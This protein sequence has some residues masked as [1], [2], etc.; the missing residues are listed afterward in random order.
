MVE[1]NV[2]YN[3][4]TRRDDVRAVK[5]SSKPHFYNGYVNTFI[6]KVFKGQGCCKFKERRV[7]RLKKLLSFSTKST[8]YCCG[9]ICPLMRIRSLKSTKWG[10]V[11]NP[12]RSPLCWSIAAMVCA[13]LPFPFVPATWIVLNW[14][15]GWLKWASS[16]CV[17]D[18]P[19]L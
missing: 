16:R 10:E 13:Q 3:R 18:K 8:T 1:A 5:S 11:Y 17:F 9:I 14:L 4:E 15:W 19:S 2:G 6:C 12:T 7:K